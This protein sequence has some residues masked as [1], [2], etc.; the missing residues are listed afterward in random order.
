[1]PWRLKLQGGG[2]LRWLSSM[3]SLRQW[4]CGA[5]EVRKRRG[6]RSRVDDVRSIMF[7]SR[8]M[9]TRCVV[10]NMFSPYWRTVL[11]RPTFTDIQTHHDC[12][13]PTYGLRCV[14]VF[15]MFSHWHIESLPHTNLSMSS[16]LDIIFMTCLIYPTHDPQHVWIFSIVFNNIDVTLPRLLLW[17]HWWTCLS[18]F[19]FT[20]PSR[21]L[22]VIRHPWVGGF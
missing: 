20:T 11:T 16:L 13:F 18:I 8:H 4:H 1:M 3:Y 21:R 7:P 22:S 6:S 9:V 2:K 15:Q 5:N 17:Q 12:P 10:P 14:Q 19:G